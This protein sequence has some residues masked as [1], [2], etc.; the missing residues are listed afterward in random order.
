MNPIKIAAIVLINF[1]LQATILNLFS[2]GGVIPNTGLIIVVAFS[3]IS[4]KKTGA[5]VGLSAGL[6]QD[7]L[8]S[9]V[10][11]INTLGLFSVGLLVGNLDQKVFKEN[12]FL[13]FVITMVSTVFLYLSQFFFIYFLKI[14]VSLMDLIVGDMIKELLYNGALTIFIYKAILNNYKEPTVKFTRGF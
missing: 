5:I 13:P 3:L 6:L 11:G 4:G 2:I 1:I 12:L 7:M 10:I 9:G 8:F 14:D